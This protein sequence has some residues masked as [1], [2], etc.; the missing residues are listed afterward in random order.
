[1][2]THLGHRHAADF[3]VEKLEDLAALGIELVPY[4]DEEYDQ[5]VFDEL[6]E[7]DIQVDS[8]APSFIARFW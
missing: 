7:P 6:L 3:A 1:M 5:L 4:T 8:A 2:E